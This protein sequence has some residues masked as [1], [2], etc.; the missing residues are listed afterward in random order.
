MTYQSTQPVSSFFLSSY[1]A[2]A[3]DLNRRDA[4]HLPQRLPHVSAYLR[5][6]AAHVSAY[7]RAY[8]APARLKSSGYRR[9]TAHPCVAHRLTLM[10]AALSY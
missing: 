7:L 8:A 2:V 10:Y 5:A 1:L 3:E 6:Y 9:N 4:P